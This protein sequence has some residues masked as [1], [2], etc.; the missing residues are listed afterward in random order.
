[1]PETDER[2]KSLAKAAIAECARL[3]DR[4]SVAIQQVLGALLGL[5]SGARIY[6]RRH[7]VRL[8]RAQHL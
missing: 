1:M 6:G 5:S 4:A 8:R 7:R 2:A 3:Y